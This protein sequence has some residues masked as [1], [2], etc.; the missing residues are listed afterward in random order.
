MS[1]FC[2]KRILFQSKQIQNVTIISQRTGMFRASFTKPILVKHELDNIEP[3]DSCH[4]N[5]EI[6]PPSIGESN[7]IAYDPILHKFSRILM[8]KGNSSLAYDL[9]EKTFNVIKLK[10]I[11]TYNRTKDPIKRQSI[12]LDPKKVFLKA[13]ENSKPLLKIS[14]FSKGGILYMVPMPISNKI[15]LFQAS[16][17]L[18]ES[19]NEKEKTIR[20]YDKFAD[21]LILA[22]LYQGKAIQKVKE[23]HK[24]AEAN[25]AYA[26]YPWK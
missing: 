15:S 12:E 4:L 24:K 3:S 16:K 19:G 7:S 9:I 13:V 23:I 21:E 14:P 17:L 10:Q 25:R 11:A 18:I 1:S 8:R 5:K 2:I 22:S 20:F 6:L 26:H